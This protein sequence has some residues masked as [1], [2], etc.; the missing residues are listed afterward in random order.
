MEKR[1]FGHTASGKEVYSYTLTDSGYSLEV[2]TYGAAIRSLTVPIDG[3][4]RDIASGFDDVAGY[5]AHKSYLGAV[6]GRVANRIGNARFTLN[7]K[8]YLLNQNDGSNCLHG[9]CNAYDKHVW[10]AE[11]Q[12]D[13]LV[14]KMIDSGKE[15]KFPGDIEVEVTYRLKDGAV[16]IEYKAQSDEDTPINLTNHCYFNLGGHD[17]GGIEGHYLQVFSDYFTPINDNLIPT[18]EIMDVTDTPFDM[19]KPRHIGPGLDSSHPQIVLGGGY[20]HNY[21]LSHEPVNNLSVAAVLEFGGLRMTC[22]T[23]KPGIQFYS[24]NFLTGDTGKGGAVYSKRT[25]LCLETQ[26]WPDSINK[27]EFPDCVL[28]KGETYHHKTV[29]RLESL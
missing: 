10:D 7:S 28:R 29:Y 8:E 26:S 15:S 25:G 27:K 21:V 19:R 22:E 5:E 12:G 17:S 4:K 23:T 3:E 9:G 14:L 11:G 6:I 16:E 1:L 24:G 13:A 20:D 2:L 18:G